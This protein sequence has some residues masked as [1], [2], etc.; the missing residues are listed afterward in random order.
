MD[1]VLALFVALVGLAVGSFA[2]VVIY[3]VPRGESVVSPPSECPACGARVRARHN[4]P[5]FGWLW[6]RGQC[7][8]CGA[9]IS[10]RY[11]VIEAATAIVFGVI[12]AVV[13]LAWVLPLLLVLAF[14]TIVLS[15][16]DFETRRLPDRILA[17]F[18]IL[19]LASIAAVVIGAGDAWTLS[20]AAIGAGAFGLFYLVAFLA[21]PKGMGF[22]DVKLAPV[23][24]AILG[25][26]GWEQLA[27]GGFA[28][29]FWGSV[30]GIA[31]MALQ[32]RRHGVS[33]PFGPWMFLGA[34]TGVVVGEPVARWYLNVVGLT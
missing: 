24:G 21:Y 13:G 7:A 29:F 28:A 25:T 16:V 5:V 22:G 17:P 30:V 9:P 14:F 20:R 18:A 1:S 3:R 6:L 26:F 31:A 11:P 15:A 33:I 27:V 8:D 32:R 23:L 2:N 12:G 19:S 4:V 34:W 10:G